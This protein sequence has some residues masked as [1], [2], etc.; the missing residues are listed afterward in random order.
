MGKVALPHFPIS[1]LPAL[2]LVSMQ[3]ENKL[4]LDELTLLW[5]SCVCSR[6]HPLGY[7]SHKAWLLDLRGLLLA[8]RDK[9]ISIHLILGAIVCYLF[10]K[11]RLGNFQLKPLNTVYCMPDSTF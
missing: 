4:L 5:I 3:K 2:A 10:N 9:T 11:Y 6:T 1:L 7:W 8:L